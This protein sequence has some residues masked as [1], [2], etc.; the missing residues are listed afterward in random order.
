[1]S[2]I[3]RTDLQPEPPAV[4]QGFLTIVIRYNAKTSKLLF[5]VPRDLHEMLA[6][7]MFKRAVEKDPQQFIDA[8]SLDDPDENILTVKV[9]VDTGEAE[10]GFYSPI[11]NTLLEKEAIRD[12]LVKKV[13]EQI[14]LNIAIRAAQSSSMNVQPA[15]PSFLDSLKSMRPNGRRR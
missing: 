4:E 11:K 15:L 5:Q 8:A 2:E 14:A 10:V 7:F 13:R 6:D 1:M 9:S 3:L 12:W